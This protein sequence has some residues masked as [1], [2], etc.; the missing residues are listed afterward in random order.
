VA[1]LVNRASQPGVPFMFFNPTGRAFGRGS[2]GSIVEV[3]L[4]FDHG[5]P[6]AENF[7]LVNT[8]GDPTPCQVI[9]LTDHFEM[10]VLKGQRKRAV[11]CA[12][13]IEDLPSCGYRIYYAL[14]GAYI[15]EIQDPVTAEAAA[16]TGAVLENRYLR[17]TVQ[18]DGSLDVFD[19][20]A[21]RTYKTQAYLEDEE[22]A[23]DT[24]D[25]SP[26]AHGSR[27]RSLGSQA[28]ISL[29]HSGPLSVACEIRLDMHLPARLAPDRQAR[30]AETITCRVVTTLSLR[31]DSRSIELR[32]EIDN[33]AEDHRLRV[34]F[35]TGVLTDE[36]A[37]GGHFDV[38]RRPIDLPLAVGWAQPPVPTRHQNDFV[39]VSDGHAGLA[40][41]NRG[42][43]EYEI[44]RDGLHPGDNTIAVTLL[45]CVGWLSRGDMPS[46]PSHAGVPVPTPEAQCLGRHT[47]EYAIV[48]HLGDWHAVYQ[49]A[50]AY[51]APLYVRRGD[52]REG[53][54]PG[55]VWEA[56]SPNDPPK[57]SGAIP[58]ALDG[59][60]PG[61]L[62]F[63]TLKPE[64]LVLSA[65]KRSEAGDALIVRCYNPTN[66][67]QQA[68]LRLFRP[69]VKAHLADLREGAGE[70]LP[71]EDDG[72]VRFVVN[73]KG[74]QTIS[75][76][77]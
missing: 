11:R 44:L 34:C 29:L 33:C 45:R 68:S 37:A 1:A 36:A 63:L 18:P 8:S 22:D 52:E 59:E 12:V 16:G 9:E 5:D 66:E 35:P 56:N 57:W 64:G 65:I 32:T 50:E 67:A 42:L 76:Q 10:E 70:A 77:L 4:L 20:L 14:P 25:Y 71:I 60:L 62:S 74:I 28:H 13:Q 30:S 15:A 49:A 61:E 24:Y 41:F 69:I 53:Y 48:P 54:L 40:V 2:T 19:K 21:G 23:G 46:R 17:V 3:S 72:L 47:F 26:A 58:V 51:V 27:V 73:P 39:D 75:L 6:L 43:P 38:I 7:R 31:K 55:E